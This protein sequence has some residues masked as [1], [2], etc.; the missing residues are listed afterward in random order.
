MLNPE[1]TSGG[2][3]VQVERGEAPADAGQAAGLVSGDPA[4]VRLQSVVQ[5]SPHRINE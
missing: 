2:E 3:L 4:A 1:E 5:R